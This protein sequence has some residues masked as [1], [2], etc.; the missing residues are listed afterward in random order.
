MDRRVLAVGLCLAAA[1]C[2]AGLLRDGPLAEV[3]LLGISSL[4]LAL[5]GIFAYQGRRQRWARVMAWAV[6][7]AVLGGGLG[8]VHART[9]GGAGA[10]PGERAGVT[11]HGLQLI[12]L[13]GCLGLAAP[14]LLRR[15]RLDLRPWVP[16]EP[17]DPVHTLAL[18]FTLSLTLMHLVPLVTWGQPPFLLELQQESQTASAVDPRIAT[19]AELVWLI[20]LTVVLTGYGVSRS[21]SEVLDRLGLR[22]F[23]LRTVGLGVGLG[24]VL[25]PVIWG[26]DAGLG[27]LWQALG[28][29]TTDAKAVELLFREFNNP[30]G[31][32]AVAVS[33]GVGEELLVRG[34]LQPRM[35]LWLSNLF[36]ASIHAPQYYW[37]ALLSVFV[38]GLML[39]WLRRRTNLW[40][41]M[42]VHG[43]FDFVVVIW[44]WLSHGG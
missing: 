25:V 41:C 30:M 10:T 2:V 23:G 40:V 42:L 8:A 21:F 9:L 7:L 39:G 29:P 12:C 3:S 27:A 22:G 14:V 31:A 35:G 6:A 37:D 5:L 17:D 34:L 1:L 44:P 32:V 24:L 18:F 4:P 33:A 38:T 11:P 13:M 36:F 15:V 16:V 28:W 26:V 19:L 43:V 20:P